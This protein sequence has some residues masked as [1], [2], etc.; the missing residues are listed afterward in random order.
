ML[1]CVETIEEVKKVHTMYVSFVYCVL[2]VALSCV[3]TTGKTHSN[4]AP[5][6]N[7]HVGASNFPSDNVRPE[8]RVSLSIAHK[9][10]QEE[11]RLKGN[12]KG[13][14]GGLWRERGAEKARWTE[15][16]RGMTRTGEVGTGTRSDASGEGGGG[17]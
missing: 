11:K 9:N 7:A 10:P 12:N 14:A 15:G 4:E 16:S 5:I 6:R 1:S 8:G 17:V 13:G 2:R 3:E